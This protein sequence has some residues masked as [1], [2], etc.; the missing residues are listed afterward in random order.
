MYKMQKDN[1]AL[2]WKETTKET[3]TPIADSMDD[4]TTNLTPEAD[5]FINDAVDLPIS[6]FDLAPASSLTT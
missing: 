3:P 2:K 6:T 5:P 1:T 4:T